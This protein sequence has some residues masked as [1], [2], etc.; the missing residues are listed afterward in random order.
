MSWIIADGH[1]HL[2]RLHSMEKIIHAA[3]I[4]FRAAESALALDGPTARFLFLTESSGATGFEQLTKMMIRH[5][6]LANFSLEQTEESHTIRISLNDNRPLYIIA[7]R[8]IVTS[9]RLEVLALGYSQDYPDGESV[10]QVLEKLKEAQSLSVLPWGA[11]KWLG[12]RGRIIDEIVRRPQSVPIFLGD[13]A[14]RPVFW[15]QPGV[16]KTAAALKIHN[17]PGSDPLPFHGQENKIGGFGFYLP[18]AIC[19]H[20]PFSSVRSLLCSSRTK[21]LPY[22]RLEDFYHFCKHQISMQFIKSNVLNPTLRPR[23]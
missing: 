8:Q 17:L 18:G 4:N 16:F 7:G 14:N 22:G 20:Q 15:P 9:E 6:P 12:R 3:A 10:N 13:N 11:G 23:P 1:V 5:E 19:D 2:H 21:P